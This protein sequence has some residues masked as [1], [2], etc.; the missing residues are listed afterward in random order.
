MRRQRGF[1]LMEV[2]IAAALSAIVSAA[3]LS[4]VRTQ[5]ITFEMNDQ[6]SRTQENARAA[7]DF[8]ETTVRRAC[9][10]IS[11][12]SVGVN[13]PGVSLTQN[14]I[15]C[16]RWYD[17]ATV[18]GS[19]FGVGNPTTGAA[20]ALEVIYATGTMAA[21]TVK[22]TLSTTNSVS[23]TDVSGFVK[24]DYVLVGDYST[25]YLFKV[26]GVSPGPPY[27]PPTAGTLALGTVG[28]LVAPSPAP[29]LDIG[30]PV[31]KAAAYSF[32][33][34]PKNNPATT[35]DRMLIADADGP[36]STDHTAYGTTGNVQPVVEG[37][38]DFQ[39]AVGA[40]TNGDGIVTESTSSPNTD[41][42]IGNASSEVVSSVPWNQ[43]RQVR[44][45][46]LLNTLNEYPGTL[47]AVAAFEDGQAHLA[48]A[49]GARYRSARM[50]VAPRA[51]N[52]SE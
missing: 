6:V 8:V 14:P 21:L 41:E 7:M 2:M 11:G 40:D 1:T 35:Y 4:I 3:V 15:P 42:W 29:A 46:L 25:A 9:G 16:L 51:W 31:L 12:G 13:V 22:P 33:V 20:D 47:T 44:I 38:L 18:S 24:D 10:G 45:S 48:V 28:T 30:S 50:V 32:F 23:V 17:A 26:S 49:A 34:V 39:I 19:S 52:L 37:V 36:M 43:L 5:L 27:S